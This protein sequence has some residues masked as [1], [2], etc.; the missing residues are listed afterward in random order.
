LHACLPLTCILLFWGG[1]GGFALSN[2]MLS[3]DDDCGH[4]C[5]SFMSVVHILRPAIL[6]DQK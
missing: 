4:R 1:A 2:F 3:T 6:K 5:A